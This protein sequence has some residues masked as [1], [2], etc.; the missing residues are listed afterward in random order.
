MAYSDT[1]EIMWL[2]VWGNSTLTSV[3]LLGIFLFLCYKKRFNIEETVMVIMPVLFGLVTVEY[4][5]LWIKGLL[6]IPIGA[7]WGLAVLRIAGLR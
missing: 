3:A 5:S 2:D 1:I 6:V 7:L 4:L